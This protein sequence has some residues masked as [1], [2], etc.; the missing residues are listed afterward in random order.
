MAKGRKVKGD[1]QADD[2]SPISAKTVATRKD[3]I[4]HVAMGDTKHCVV[5]LIKDSLGIE[6]IDIRFWFTNEDMKGVLQASPKG[7][8]LKR[9]SKETRELLEAALAACTEEIVEEKSS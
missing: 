8:S 3:V 5:A 6:Y 7:V 4:K 2:S 9:D 1:Q